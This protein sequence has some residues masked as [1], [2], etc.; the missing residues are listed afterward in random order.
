MESKRLQFRLIEESDAPFLYRLMNTKNWLENIGDRNIRNEYD[1]IQYMRNKMHPDLEV[2][3][4]INYVM[5]EKQSKQIVGTCSIH[6]RDGVDGI[7]IGY[8]LLPQF[9]GNG[10][11]SEGASFLVNKVFEEFKPDKIS[12]ITTDENIGSCR[13]LEKI[14]FNH[15]DYIKI[16]GVKEQLKL[17]T[18]YPDK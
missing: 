11:A 15:E 13:L 9:E 6:N 5:I 1:A 8:A 10:F 3:G 2:K 4:F 18:L 17:Y 7:D 12:A 16:P 14:G